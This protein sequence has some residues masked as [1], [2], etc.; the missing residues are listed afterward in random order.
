[1]QDAFGIVI[2]VVMGVAVVAAL[3]SF[4]GRG[5][6]Y[7][8]I[9]RGG[10]ALRDERDAPPP[11]P[12]GSAGAAAVRDE[13]IRQMLD[14]QNVRRVR[15]GQPPLDVDDEVRR[16]TRTAADSGLRAEVRQLVIARNARRERAGK[17]P[18]DVEQEIE[19]QLAQFDG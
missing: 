11:D 14:A 1:M 2:F 17:E 19:R 8:Q 12:V 9:G 15:R 4:I 5:R 3:A 13:E 18:L 7:D 6:L 16:L 10:L